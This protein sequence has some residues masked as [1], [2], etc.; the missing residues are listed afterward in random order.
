MFVMEIGKAI[1]RLRELKGWTYYKLAKRA[2]VAPGTVSRIERGVMTKPSPDTLNKIAMALGVSINDIYNPEN[3][4]PIKETPLEIIDKMKDFLDHYPRQV[5]SNLD[6]ADKTILIP[7]RCKLPN[8]KPCNQLCGKQESESGV[9]G[10]AIVLRSDLS[11]LLDIKHLYA[12]LVEGESFASLGFHDQDRIVVTPTNRIDVEGA[13]YLVTIGERCCFRSFK[14]VDERYIIHG[15]AVKVVPQPRDLP[16][17]TR[18]L[19][20]ANNLK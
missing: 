20:N 12:V 19:H 15:R 18:K 17:S 1:N 8:D 5:L 14:Y 10:Y 7:I 6:N 3:N 16:M 13:L 2:G 9:E 4:V 11:D